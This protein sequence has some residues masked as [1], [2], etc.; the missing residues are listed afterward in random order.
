M[1]TAKKPIAHQI[2]LYNEAPTRPPTAGKSEL[3][4]IDAG[5]FD[6]ANGRLYTMADVEWLQGTYARLW[7]KSAALKGRTLR[8]EDEEEEE[9][10]EHPLAEIVREGFKSYREELK[11]LLKQ[12]I[13]AE[14]SEQLADRLP[15]GLKRQ[16]G[17]QDDVSIAR[18]GWR[19][20]CSTGLDSWT[21]FEYKLAQPGQHRPHDFAIVTGGQPK[22]ASPGGCVAGKGYNDAGVQ[23]MYRPW[24]AKKGDIDI[25]S[26]YMKRRVVELGFASGQLKPVESGLQLCG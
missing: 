11:S 5:Y 25:L 17:D 24:I 26:R 1:V 4:W 7:K 19:K 8:E 12:K 10:E 18:L 3:W 2:D 22:Q 20:R 21:M 16:I 13:E 9:E 14:V 6:Q 15:S 23:T